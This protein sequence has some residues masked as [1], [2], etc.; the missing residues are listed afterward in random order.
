MPL[1]PCRHRRSPV[2]LWSLLALA[3]V[4]TPS[5]AQGSS[6]AQRDRDDELPTLPAALVTA[7]HSAHPSI[8]TPYTAEAVTAAEIER[9]SYR[10][11]PQILNDT[12]GVLVQETAPGHGS[13]YIRGF[14]SLRTVFLVDG[15]RLNNSV[16]R[17]G[18]NQYWNTVDPWSIERLEVVK[19]PSSV[20]YGSDAIGGTVNA[21]TRNPDTYGIGLRDRE[22]LLYRTSTAEHS[23]IGRVEVTATKDD[24]FG[25]LA[26]GG[27]ADFG[28]VRGGPDVGTQRN[29]GYEAGNA[30][31]KV[32][33]FLGEDTRLVFAHQRVRLYDVPRTH[34]TIWSEPW[35]GTTSGS[36]LKRD[37]DQERDLTYVQ[38]YGKSEASWFDDYEVSL[39]WHR[40]AEERNRIKGS[41]SHERQGFEVGTLG[42]FA[43]FV[44]PSAA[45][46]WTWGFDYYRDNVDSF[47][48]GNPIQGPVA[49]DAT[50]DM[51]GLFVQDEIDAG[52]RWTF[53]LGARVQRTAVDA[54]QVQDPVGGDRMT[55]DEDWRAAVGSARFLYRLVKGRR[56][57]FGGV[58]QGFRAPNLS[59]LTRFDSARSNEYEIPAPGLDP[60]RYT[61]YELGIKE[62]R[63]SVTA[64]GALFF[65]DVMDRIVRFPTGNVN[66]DGEFE[67][68]KDNV[69]DGYV[70]GIELAGTWHF[71]PRWSIFGDATYMEGKVD[72]YPTSDPEK[73][74]EYIDRLMPTTARFGVRWES[75]KRWCEALGTWADD[76]DR[77]S[78]RDAADTERI[79]PGGTPGYVVLHARGG[80]R[81]NEHVDVRL[82]FENI[83][84]ED[85]RIHGSGSNR[86]GR[87][88]LFGLTLT[89]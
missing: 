71:A 85:Y 59:D 67:I 24:V 10:T 9:R 61:T 49:D 53:T 65:T 82:A 86:P 66:G 89:R 32:E 45:G 23:H 38:V 64:Q 42:L 52:E 79:P 84:D 47:K 36:D 77:L 13:P 51:L 28:D 35:E 58:S 4:G 40:Q 69:G 27:M 3:A 39:S 76:A 70:W 21:L 54:R 33:R 30:D 20:L 6:V 63:E 73:K 19:G 14:T 50:Y 29:T 34:S 83:T 43:N 37:T 44:T 11:T 1:S 56:H 81:I 55:I 12:A 26:G 25:I 87:S 5:L 74:R 72:T 41:G 15:I 68:T 31:V 88:V 8:E 16:F 78:T 75:A 48:D 62:E 46:T 60:E 7:T 18:P 2:P 57:L 17:E 80:W 22:R